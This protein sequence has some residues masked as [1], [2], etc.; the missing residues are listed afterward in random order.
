MLTSRS[1]NASLKEGDG[2]GLYISSNNIKSMNGEIKVISEKGIGSEFIVT[3]P[4]N[5]SIK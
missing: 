3:L 4:I 1:E 5:T 2:L